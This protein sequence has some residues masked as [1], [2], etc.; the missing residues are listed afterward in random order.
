ML[1]ARMSALGKIE[2]ALEKS[3]WLCLR[4]L[5]RLRDIALALGHS[6]VHSDRCVKTERLDR[7]FDGFALS[8]TAGACRTR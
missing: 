1:S 6:S 3:D 5:T 4:M 2:V 7:T 8:S